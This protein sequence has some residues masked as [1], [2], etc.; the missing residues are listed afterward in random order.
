MPSSTEVQNILA[1]L[2]Q[3]RKEAP[4]KENSKY[5]PR[6]NP[7]RVQTNYLQAVLILIRPI[8]AESPTNLELI[9]LCAT[10][11]ADACE[12]CLFCLTKGT[13]L[14]TPRC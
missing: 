11:A 5:F 4:L 7:D 1:K 3:W 6:Q 13:C 8:L 14:D 10:F 12:V 9:G 2:K